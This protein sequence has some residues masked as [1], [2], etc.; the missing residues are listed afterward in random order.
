M[1]R[2][3]IIMTCMLWVSIAQAVAPLRVVLD[4]FVNPDH[5]PLFLAQ[6]NGYFKDAGLEVELIAPADPS[7]PPKLVAAGKA[8]IAIDY[9][10]RLLL[11]R[12]QGLPIAQVGTLIDQPLGCLAV[13]ASSPIQSIADLKGK[14]IAYSSAT[15]DMATLSTMLAA[16]GMQMKDVEPIAVGYGLTQALLSQHADAAIGVMRNIELA[17]LASVGRPARAFYPEQHG[18]PVYDEL[19]FVARSDAVDDA[20]VTQF[21]HAV[22]RGVAYL[23]QHPE[24]AWHA[25]VAAHPELNDDAN[26][27]AWLATVPYFAQQP[28]DFS[29]SRCAALAA[30]LHLSDVT[31]R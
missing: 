23:R 31:C 7:D 25:F 6:Q 21:L 26:H 14:R 19:V 22:Q 4:W 18:F 28:A 27:R 12:A 3:L 8:D 13:L 17:Q 20:R 11:E 29:A 2:L 15:V 30:A 24:A 9:Q 5:A 1:I 10:P 16:H